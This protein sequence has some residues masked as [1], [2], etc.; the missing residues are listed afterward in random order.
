LSAKQKNEIDRKVD[1]YKNSSVNSSK[2]DKKDSI[3]SFSNSR[4]ELGASSRYERLY[5]NEDYKYAKDYVP[6][7][8]KLEDSYNY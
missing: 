7:S 2:L 3:Y 5:Q 6:L 4:K 8:K 1:S